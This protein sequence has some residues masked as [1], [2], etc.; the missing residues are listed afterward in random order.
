L[1]NTFLVL[2]VSIMGVALIGGTVIVATTLLKVINSQGALV[3][4]ITDKFMAKDWKQYSQGEVQLT[5]AETY[6]E[7]NDEE[8][9]ARARFLADQQ[10]REMGAVRSD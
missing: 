10:L 4:D 5:R 3:R 1:T 6:S 2:L 7:M 8:L 9:H